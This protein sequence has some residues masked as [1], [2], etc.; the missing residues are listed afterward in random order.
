MK[1]PQRNNR[2]FTLVELLVAMATGIVVIGAIYALYTYFLRTSEGQDKL[3]EIQQEARV[4]MERLAKEIRAAGCYYRNTPIITA[5]STQFE[6]ESDIDPDPNQGPWK[7][8][9]ELDATNKEILRSSA[10]WNGTS[11]GS[12][13]TAQ[14][15]AGHITGLQFTYYDENGTVITAPVNSQANRDRIRRVDIQITA[16]TDN[17]NPATKTVDTITLTTSVYTR[18]MGVQQSTDT[19]PCANPTNLASTDPGIC[20]RLNLTW[21]KSTS[22]DAAGYRIYYRPTGSTFYS[23]L[24]DVA[25][26]STESYTLTGL[27]NG[28]QYDIAIKC[29]DTSGNVN[30]SFEGPI[31]GTSGTTDTKPD[32]STAPDLPTGADATSGDGYTT[33][34][35]TASTA[36]DT[37]GYHVYRSD[38]GGVTYT[39]VAEVDSTVLSYTDTSVQNCPSTPYYYKVM[40][41]DCASN[42]QSLSSQSAVYGDGSGT[43]ADSPTSGV[44][45]TNPFETVP[46][47]DPS[48]FTAVAGADKV[49]L[50]YATPADTDLKGVRILRRT[51]QYPTD[52][53]DAGAVGPNNQTDYEPLNVSQTYSLVDNYGVV[54]GNTYYYRAFAYDRC[55]NFSA[56][57]ISQATAAPC[58]DGVPGS[59]HY[60]PPA[61]PSGVTSDVCSV[62]TINWT[63]STGSENGNTFNPA[64]ENDVVGYNVYRST[65]SGGPYT[66]INTT[67]I[68]STSYYDSTVV[69]GNSYY[70]VVTAVDCAG[71]ESTITSPETTVI[72][73]DVDWD[74]NVKVITYGTSGVSGSQH[75]VVKFGIKNLGN[76][77]VTLDSAVI[78]WTTSTAKLKKV[79]L[80]PFGSSSNTLWDGTLIDSGIT[81]DFSSYQPDPSLR[82]LGAGSTLNELELDFRDSSGTGYVDMRGA[83]I[84]VTFNYT[85]D[86]SSS[87]C[88]STSFSV[89]VSTGPTI[90][91]STQNRP[92]QPTTSN[93]NAGT[94]V[95]PAGTQDAS[96]NWTLYDVTVQNT[97]TLETLTTLSS[98][99][100]YYTTTDRSTTTAPFTDYSASPAG[101]TAVTMCQVGTTNTYQTASSGSC[102]TS[103]IPNLPGKRVWYYTKVIDSNTNYDIQP[104][105]SVGIYTY[106]QEAKF[107]IY[108][109]VTRS[110]A[111]GQ[112]VSVS[113]DLEDQDT[114]AVSGA[115][116]SIT[117]TG[118]A[119]VETGTM[120][121]S[122]TAGTYTYTA[123]GNYHDKQ[124]SVTIAVSKSTFTSASCGALN[125]LKTDTTTTKNC[126]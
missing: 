78:T 60:G 3:I 119:T 26:G 110:G 95:V 53:N 54:V 125:I 30:S 67:P 68:T 84:T 32:D 50:S 19:T 72:P 126:L 89:P 75:N 118:A 33:L 82:R 63:A 24:I 90:T 116:I 1:A 94:I 98:A 62:A 123:T 10:L 43:N 88:S 44:T 96:Y 79:V 73:S 105:P 13:S 102:T 77:S 80:T 20:G 107:N 76:T 21:T 11:Y 48:N 45:D 97:L 124:I 36:V 9:Y 113:V 121:E 112:D 52:Q 100:L 22:S 37:G 122:A 38:D 103:P 104:E 81:V 6:F 49:Y 59:K 85:N 111:G 29:Y 108:M 74:T 117:I 99:T 109:T 58:G 114:N 34:S 93:L 25:G 7:I 5:T 14:D 12:Y 87:A 42:E 8:K 56:G 18:C 71:N 4:A 61:A 86:S 70:Y 17:P 57:T 31:S 39:Q 15:I 46:P 120:T 35:W 2:G 64:S 91:S 115:T 55:N 28:T 69:T 83:T 27:Q 40:S 65:V 23:G 16:Q 106:D 41:W 47:Q 66:K 92:V 51:D 101:W